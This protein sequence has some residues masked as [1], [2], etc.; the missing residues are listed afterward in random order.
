MGSTLPEDGDL[1]HRVTSNSYSQQQC[2]ERNALPLLLSVKRAA[3]E[4]D[5]S[6]D[7]LRVRIKDGR[8]PAT[9]LG[10]NIRLTRETVLE[11]AGKGNSGGAA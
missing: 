5:V 10:R 4:L 2:V 9:K 6:E 3:R 8:I 7:F 1:T 11:L